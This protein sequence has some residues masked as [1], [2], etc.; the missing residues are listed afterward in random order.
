VPVVVLSANAS[1]AGQDTT[2]GFMR[3][4]V[5]VQSLLALVA[6]YCAGRPP[7]DESACS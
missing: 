6:S 7:G 5:K 1:F 4:P 3:K 2:V